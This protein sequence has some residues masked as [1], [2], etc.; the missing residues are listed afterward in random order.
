V[1]RD[2]SI[3]DTDDSTGLVKAILA[4]PNDALREIVTRTARPHQPYEERPYAAS[5]AEKAVSAGEQRGARR[6]ERDLREPTRRFRRDFA[7]VSCSRSRPC[8]SCRAPLRYV[9]ADELQV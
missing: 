3:Y 9:L 5:G 4:A 2:F 1:R 6:Y 7:A 8:A